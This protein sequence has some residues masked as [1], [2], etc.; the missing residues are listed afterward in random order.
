MDKA[1]WTGNNVLGFE[2]ERYDTGADPL[3]T[4]V[5]GANCCCRPRSTCR[6]SRPDGHAAH[7]EALIDHVRLNTIARRLS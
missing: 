7:R 2:K 3:Q 6:G 1:G 5:L 4:I